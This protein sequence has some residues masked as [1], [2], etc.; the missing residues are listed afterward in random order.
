M[1]AKI[2]RVSVSSIAEMEM[3]ITT[4]G[5][6]GFDVLNKTAN[7]VTLVKRKR[8]NVIWSVIG[9]LL[10][11]VPLLIYIVIYM[12]QSDVIIEITVQS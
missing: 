7:S 8:F 1:A 12:L 5:A 4:Y 11:V 9:F 10:C 2:Q 3:A 6:Q